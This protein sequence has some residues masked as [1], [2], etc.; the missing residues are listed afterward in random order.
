MTLTRISF[1]F[2]ALALVA[3][4]GVDVDRAVEQRIEASNAFAVKLHRELAG[5]EDG[6]IIVSPFS[7]SSAFGMIYAGARSRTAE[8]MARAFAF[9]GSDDEV[10]SALGRL[11]RDLD[12]SSTVAVANRLWCQ[13]SF[14]LLESFTGLLKEKYDASAGSADF[15]S[16]PGGSTES[17]NRWVAEQTQ[18]RIKDLL[19]PNDVDQDTR[20][21]LVNAIYFKA[22]WLTEFRKSSTT[23]DPHFEVTPG[24][25]VEVP[26]MSGKLKVRRFDAPEVQVVELPYA[27]SDL[28]MDI[29]LPPR[30]VALSKLEGSLDVSRLEGWLGSLT[31]DTVGVSMPRF[32]ARFKLDLEGPLRKLGMVEAF[33]PAA[34]LSGMT[35]K[36]NLH[37]SFARHQAFIKVDETGTEAAA[38]TAGGS[39]LISNTDSEWIEVDRPFLFLIRDTASGAILFMG[40]VVDPTAHAV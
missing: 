28:A 39:V 33:S 25:F 7:I 24:N 19:E 34:D 30:G 36:K 11:T 35:G 22:D 37:I 20:V 5:T 1:L 31:R 27:G 15:V 23:T 6:N 3:A 4:C 2:P 10:H 14:S 12:R 40:R 32:E 13:K 26:M 21:V 8:E 9:S 18:D 16:D 17:I 38:A 29:L